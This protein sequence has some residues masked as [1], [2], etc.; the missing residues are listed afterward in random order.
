[1][2]TRVA[3]VGA[4]G[5]LGSQIARIVNDSPDFELVASLTSGSSLSDMEAAEIAVDATHP[6]ASPGIV[7]FGVEHGVKMLVGTSG[8][9]VDRIKPIETLVGQTPGS[10]VYIVPNFSL[11]AMMQLRVARMLAREFDSVEI[12]ETHHVH[13]ADS[14]SGTAI[15]TAEE[16]ARVRSEHG[17]VVAPHPN[18]VARGEQVA[19]IP[20][21][22]LRLPGV[23][24]EQSVVFG[25]EGETITI[26]HHTQS[27][28][29]YDVGILR[30]LEFVRDNTGLHVGLE[31][32][33]EG[34]R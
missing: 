5:R 24:A 10:T 17:G 23:M 18:Q 30:S 22:S 7:Q 32:A 26:T 29:A 31:H 3:I 27:R 9:S 4:S 2:P 8:W 13:K 16:I 11:G 21:H 12:T 15:R 25:G 33:V 34:T 14:P 19:G 1:M 6:S 28:D 20:V